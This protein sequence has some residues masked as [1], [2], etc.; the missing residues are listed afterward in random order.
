MDLK[1]LK[2]LVDLER[3]TVD[4]RI[5]WDRGI[6]ELELERIFARCWLFVAHESQVE[7]PG[8]FLTTYMGE[9]AVI[10]SRGTDKRIHVFLNSCSHR[11]NRVCFAEAGTTR[12]FTCNYHGWSYALDGSLTGLPR[13]DIYQKTCPGFDKSKLGL[14]KARVESYRGLVFATF[15]AEAPGLDEYLGDFRWYLDI[16]LDNDEGGT[17]FIDG[18]IKSE[19]RCNWKIPAE[20]FVGDSYHAAWTHNS[21]AAAMLGVPV[22]IPDPERTFAANMNG[23]GWQFGLD[24]VGNA[25]TLGEKDIVDYLRGRAEKVAARLGKLRSRMVGS[26]ASATVFPHLSFLPGQSTFRTWHPKGPDRIELHT[27]VLVNRSAPEAIKEM[28]RRGVM[29][30][31]SPAGNFEMDDGENWENAT[32]SA[33]GHVTRRQRLHYGLGMGGRLEHEELKGNVYRGKYNDVN[34]RAFYGRWLELMSAERWADLRGR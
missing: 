15:D 17:E 4:R 14:T 31:F 27:W 32:Q 3:G 21:G 33:R 7:A 16:L 12:R 8:A 2:S 5:F 26:V 23:H 9:D 22:M 10:V 13:E 28:Y 1:D 19:M 30:T 24:M 18:N 34:Q 20:N 11:G 29:R 6:Y 25:Q